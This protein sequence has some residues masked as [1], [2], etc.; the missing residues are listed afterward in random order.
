MMTYPLLFRSLQ[1]LLTLA[2]TLALFG[3]GFQLAGQ[4]SLP[5]ELQRI[6]LIADDT[7]SEIY[8][9]LERELGERGVVLDRK[10]AHVL[11]L[12]R[13]E[14]GQRVLSVSARNIPREFEVYYTVGFNLLRDGQAL[15]DQP[16]LTLTRDYQWSELEVL[17]K[18]REERLLR[19]MI[20]ADLVDTILLQIA[21]QI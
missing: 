6:A 3:C 11:T 9:A 2:G 13:V 8:L 7:R 16:N 10:A 21:T 4:A 14:T 19:E 1:C 18:V 12:T 20:V 17:G 5:A 15:I